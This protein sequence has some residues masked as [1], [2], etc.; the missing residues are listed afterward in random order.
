[1]NTF[2]LFKKMLT[3]IFAQISCSDLIEIEEI[4]NISSQTIV[5]IRFKKIED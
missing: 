1:M 3:Q 2:I 5:C 4:N